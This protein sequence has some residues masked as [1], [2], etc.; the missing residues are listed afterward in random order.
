MTFIRYE[1]YLTLLQATL[2][3]SFQ[4]QNIIWLKEIEFAQLDCITDDLTDIS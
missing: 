4:T 2:K 1:N 3:F